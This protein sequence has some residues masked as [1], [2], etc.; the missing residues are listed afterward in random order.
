M[1]NT[2]TVNNVERGNKQFQGLFREMWTVTATISDQDAVAIGD[3]IT[4]NM[5]VPGVALGDMVVGM[6][7]SV[8]YFDGDGDGAVISAS[9]GSAN[10]VLFTMH[11]DVAQF[12][13]DALN[14]GVIK[15]LVGRPAW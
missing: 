15:L 13:A 14:D 2:I 7:L 6:S 10:T 8:D 9:V 12:A 4:V 11:A 1:A 5:T 3:T